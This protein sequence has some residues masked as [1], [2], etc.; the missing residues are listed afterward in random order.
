MAREH[1]SGA[2]CG[3]VFNL[4]QGENQVE[5][6][7]RLAG[8]GIGADSLQ[9]KPPRYLAQKWPDFGRV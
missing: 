3:E 9:K 6:A 5:I 8:C 1:H 7:E 4:T 2:S